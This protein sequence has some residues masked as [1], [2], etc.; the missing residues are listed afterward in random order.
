MS[1]IGPRAQSASDLLPLTGHAREDDVAAWRGTT[2][3]TMR[4]LLDDVARTAAVLPEASHVLNLCA[5]RYRFAVA[6]LAAHAVRRENPRKGPRTAAV[7]IA[8]LVLLAVPMKAS[9]EAI[10]ARTTDANPTG[11]GEQYSAYLRVHSAGVRYE[12]AA[13]NPLSIVGL[14]AND[15]R[16]R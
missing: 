2:P 11:S 16:S 13:T 14:I 3:V 9:I 7:T 10:E 6:Y 12:A 8:L 15:G 4:A 5:G 1:S